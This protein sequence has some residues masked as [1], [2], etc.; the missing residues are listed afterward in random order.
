MLLNI[1]KNKGSIE[2]RLFPDEK[3]ERKQLLILERS[4][5]N[6]EDLSKCVRTHIHI[7]AE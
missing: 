6:K 1:R 3:L 5:N 7:T 4:K 2:K